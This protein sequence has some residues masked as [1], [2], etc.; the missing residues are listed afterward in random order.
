MNKFKAWFIAQNDS[1]KSI[2]VFGLTIIVTGIIFLFAS[3]QINRQANLAMKPYSQS[4]EFV[5]HYFDSLAK[6]AYLP[7]KYFHLFKSQQRIMSIRKDHYLG[8]SKL[9][10]RNYYGVLIITMIYS[11]IGGVVLF[12]MINKG[13]SGSSPGLK[14]LFLAIV[15][16]LTFCGFF[17]LVFHQ[18]ENF[19]TNIKYYM[20]YTK[21]ELNIIDQLSRLENPIFPFKT[22]TVLVNDKK[23]PIRQPDSMSFYRNID[24]MITVNINTINTLTNQVLTID[25]KEI[26]SMGEVYKT[27][28]NSTAGQIDSLRK[29]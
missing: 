29:K 14:S 28:S 18:Q 3:W 6:P 11:C 27:L 8:L 1:V 15:M 2:T 19:N 23:T 25:A 7:D 12:L 20:D 13:W 26:K 16:V 5:D 17:P 22:D 10:F 21:A 24:S 9:F 4:Q